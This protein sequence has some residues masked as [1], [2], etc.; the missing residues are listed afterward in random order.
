MQVTEISARQLHAARVY[1]GLAHDDLARRA[2]VHER[3]VRALERG[4]YA[5]RPGEGIAANARTLSRVIAILESYGIRFVQDG[6]VLQRAKGERQA[7]PLAMAA[8]AT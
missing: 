3:T 7:E 5:P 6:V 2:G 4:G 8:A 1:A